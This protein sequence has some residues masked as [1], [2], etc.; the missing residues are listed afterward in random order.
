MRSGCD[1]QRNR[2]DSIA[3]LIDR[4]VVHPI[5]V[6]AVNDCLCTEKTHKQQVVHTQFIRHLRC[7]PRST[8]PPPP[9]TTSTALRPQQFP[10]SPAIPRTP[11]P[12]ATLVKSV[13]TAHHETTCSDN[14]A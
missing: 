10:S 5:R 3:C 12:A 9:L 6:R 14:S 8:S 7:P 2:Q 13:N 11:A 1:A 4:I